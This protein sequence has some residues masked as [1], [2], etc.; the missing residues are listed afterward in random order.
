MLAHLVRARCTVQANHVDTQR[1]QRRQ[2]RTNLRA[3]QH[4]ACGL[5][6]HVDDDRNLLL[7]LTHGGFDAVDGRLYL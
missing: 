7:S 1:L 3:H 2:G 4:G 5:D 6:G